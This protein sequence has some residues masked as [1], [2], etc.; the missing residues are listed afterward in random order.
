[1]LSDILIA[2]GP[3]TYIGCWVVIIFIILV[4]QPGDTLKAGLITYAIMPVGAICQSG[5]GYALACIGL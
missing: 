5:T 4:Y 2:S 1:M 3:V